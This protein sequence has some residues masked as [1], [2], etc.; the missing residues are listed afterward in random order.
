MVVETGSVAFD[1]D[2]MVT[3]EGISADATVSVVTA[4]T[5][6]IHMRMCSARTDWLYSHHY[7]L[8][9]HSISHLRSSDCHTHWLLHVLLLRIRLSDSVSLLLRIRLR[10]LRLHWLLWVAHRLLRVS[11]GLLLVSHRLLRIAHRLLWISHRLLWVVNRLL[12]LNLNLGLLHHLN[13]KH[14]EI[15]TGAPPICTPTFAGSHSQIK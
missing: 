14:K 8:W 13:S 12:H 3:S 7:D 9:L 11:H 6:W 2:T 5:N 4:E 1:A 10:V 15:L